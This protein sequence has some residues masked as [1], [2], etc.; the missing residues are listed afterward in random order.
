MMTEEG[1]RNGRKKR[2]SR[3]E[4]RGSSLSLSAFST[5]QIM[6]HLLAAQVV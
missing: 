2:G 3:D 6:V 4:G 5:V 1:A